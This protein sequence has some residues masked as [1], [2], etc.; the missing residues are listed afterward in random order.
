VEK[1]AIDN[2]LTAL[3][4]APTGPTGFFRSYAHKDRYETYL[5]FADRKRRAARYHFQRVQHLLQIEREYHNKNVREPDFGSMDL[6]R[7]HVTDFKRTSQRTSDEFGHELCAFLAAL[8][9][10]LDF[11]ACLV[12]YHLPALQADSISKVMG[13]AK[14][15]P[16][17]S[18]C[19]VVAK[20]MDW[21]EALREYRHHL[22]HRLVIVP[23]SGH[24]FESRGKASA[25]A[26]V[27]VIVPENTPRFALD[28]REHRF[29]EDA[30]EVREGLS[31]G[32]GYSCARYD[33]GEVLFEEL[34]LEVGPVPGYLRIEDF[35]AM[36]L[37]K[38]ETFLADLATAFAEFRR[39]RLR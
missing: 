38:F 33:N 16:S 24:L 34:T 18:V 29:R 25:S 10:G 22:V 26:E 32:R 7:A 4:S 23:R 2:L 14:K 13:V 6:G 39:D 37:A 9:T 21:L 31:I 11:L 3:D 5:S 15:Y 12:P 28:T 36:H 8:K 20:W 17:S 1:D 35:M 19:A 27:P 30:A